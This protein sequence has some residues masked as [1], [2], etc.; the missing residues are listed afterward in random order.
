V[1]TGRPQY[2]SRFARPAA[3]VLIYDVENSI[4]HVT[5]AKLEAAGADQDR[6][7]FWPEDLPLQFPRD[8]DLL[9]GELKKLPKPELVIFD[10]LIS[11]LQ[12]GLNANTDADIRRAFTPLFAALRALGVA[13]ISIRHPNK[14]QGVSATDKASGSPATTALLRTEFYLGHADEDPSTITMACA[15]TNLGKMPQAIQFRLVEVNESVRL[16]YIGRSDTTANDLVADPM[17][18]A[19]RASAKSDAIEKII[20]DM[21]A[22]GKWHSS[23]ELEH[24]VKKAGGSI[25]TIKRVKKDLG[26]KSA[27]QRQPP[28]AWYWYLPSGAYPAPK[29]LEAHLREVSG[30]PDESLHPDETLSADE[31]L[32]TPDI[33]YL[34]GPNTQRLI[35]FDTPPNDEPLPGKSA[36][37]PLPSEDAI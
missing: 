3:D 5:K 36:D 1:S 9:L 27:R 13:S 35:S 7:Y 37:E 19:A 25:S 24:A 33:N 8:V 16:E 20:L 21:G 12:S 6:I 10:P 14:K 2:G 22:D 32:Q 15:K 29:P 30:A 34:E 17:V 4:A 11:T 31:P 28:R 18:R 26:V 23:V